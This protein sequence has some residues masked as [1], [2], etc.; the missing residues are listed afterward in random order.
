MFGI[1]VVSIEVGGGVV[2][3]AKVSSMNCRLEFW[4]LWLVVLCGEVVLVIRMSGSSQA[5]H[6]YIVEVHM[7]GIA[8]WGLCYVVA[9]FVV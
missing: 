4:V 6:W 7:H 8:T 3:L 1:L 9:M 5:K 2:V